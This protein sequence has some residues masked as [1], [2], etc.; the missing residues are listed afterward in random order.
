ML[1]RCL[2]A[3]SVAGVAALALLASGCGGSAGPHVASI[4]SN[5]N[6]STPKQSWAAMYHCYAAHGFPTYREVGSPSVPSAPP[7]NGWYR[8][9]NGNYVVT[10]AFLKAFS[11]PKFAAA[12]RACD[13]LGPATARTPAQVAA[14]VAQGRKFSACARAHGMPDFPDPSSQGLINLQSAGIDYE[15]PAF[16][17]VK[18]ACRSLIKNRV[19]FYAP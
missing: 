7:V 13:P 1:K 2:P 9:P 5:T 4:G 19:A 11:G 10:P 18:Q 16:Q 6:A 15:S 3:G 12:Q 8:K 14:A 17:H